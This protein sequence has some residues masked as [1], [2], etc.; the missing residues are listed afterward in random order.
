[1]PPHGWR[2]PPGYQGFRRETP[3]K[4][5]PN[6]NKQSR[7]AGP[8]MLARCPD[9]TRPTTAPALSGAEDEDPE[10]LVVDDDDDLVIDADASNVN[11]V[12][13]RTRLRQGLTDRQQLQ[14]EP[15]SQASASDSD[16]APAVP[17]L[18]LEDSAEDEEEEPLARRATVAARARRAAAALDDEDPMQDLPPGAPAPA[19][20]ITTGTSLLTVLQLSVTLS[21]SKGHCNPAWLQL[22]R[23]WMQ[24]RTLAGACALERGGRQ[25][26]LH[27][28]CMLRMHIAEHD[29]DA[30]KLELKTLVGWRRGDGTGT[31]C[32]IKQ[33]APG[34]A[35]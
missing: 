15:G 9:E 13:S 14:E 32:A 35:R 23:A 11:L 1:M 7:S 10:A 5:T 24:T 22:L 33:F 3:R 2:K 20:D 17:G 18:D 19:A 21:K 16:S 31:Y 27:L 30:L 29:I 34:Q 4:P 6:I 25:Q 8:H 28:Q 12:S 26:H